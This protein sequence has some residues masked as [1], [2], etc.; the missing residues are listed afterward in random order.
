MWGLIDC[1]INLSGGQKQRI[2]L[3]RACYSRSSTVFLDDP[4]SAVDAPTARYL[5]HK[6]ILGLLRDRT[7]IL[8]SH[9]THLVAPFADYVVQMNNGEI[10]MHG[11]PQTLVDDDRKENLIYQ[12]NLERETFSDDEAQVYTPTA[13]GD[14]TTLVKDEEKSEGS[15]SWSVYSFYFVAT[16]G[17]LF[18]ALFFGGFLLST[19]ARVLNDWWLAG[20]NHTLFLSHLLR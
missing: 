10:L 2:S 6:A 9:A 4:L 1:R 7:V 8:V 11:P 16:G 15:V 14:G 5:L 3:A 18:L 17:L 12:M 19:T 13:Q 20:K